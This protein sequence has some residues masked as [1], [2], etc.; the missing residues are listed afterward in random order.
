M[1]I[2]YP[3]YYPKFHCIAEKCRNNCCF[4][5]WE[6]DIDEESLAFYKTVEGEFGE[7]LRAAITEDNG[8]A[9]FKLDKT[10]CCPLINQNHLCDIILQTGEEHLCQ[11]CT[12]HP[13][14]RNFFSERTEI[15]VG[16]CCEEAVSLILSQTDSVRL[17]VEGDEVLTDDELALIE[18]RNQLFAIMQNREQTVKERIN[19]LIRATGEEYPKKTTKAW[20]QFLRSLERLNPSWDIRL[21]SIQQM[22]V[23]PLAVPEYQLEQLMIYFLYRHLAGA[24]DDFDLVGRVFLCLLS[25]KTICAITAGKPGEFYDIVREFSCE[26]E[27]SEENLEAILDFLWDERNKEVCD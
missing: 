21:D 13:R 12:D 24:L 15:G 6:I 11:I 9:H 7:R 23:L 20:V 3:S 22:D 8:Q 25:F 18:T 17:I 14:Y 10:G 1:S 2:C 16:L 19:E 27:Y 26:I 4:G 5:G